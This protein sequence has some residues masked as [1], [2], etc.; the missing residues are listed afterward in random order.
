MTEQSTGAQDNRGYYSF[1]CCCSMSRECDEIVMAPFDLNTIKT[2]LVI[3][4]GNGLM[5]FLES[6][7]EREKKSYSMVNYRQE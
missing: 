6:H 4:S 2:L 1:M 3:A 5:S 7:L